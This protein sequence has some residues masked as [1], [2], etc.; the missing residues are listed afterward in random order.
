MIN[1][2]SSLG[3]KRPSTLT[4]DQM[5][6]R[7]ARFNRLQTY[8]RQNFETHNIPPGA[9]EKVTARRVYPSLYDLWNED[10]EFPGLISE[11]DMFFPE[12]KIA[13]FCDSTRHHRGPK[14]QAKDA[15]IDE[16][17]RMIGVTS[18]RVPGNLIV[19]DLKAAVDQVAAALPSRS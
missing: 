17:L 5:E 16:R 7:V 18:V 11:C 8:Q 2:T 4:P 13:V 10:S 12:N 3:T 15:A 6:A 1:A 14:A 19:E 9:V